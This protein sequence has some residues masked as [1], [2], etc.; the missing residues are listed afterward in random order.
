M[1]TLVPSKKYWGWELKENA[2]DL[3]PMSATEI[4]KQYRC[5]KSTFVVL[6]AG[7]RITL[8]L[9]PRKLMIGTILGFSSYPQKTRIALFE[10]ADGYGHMDLLCDGHQIIGATRKWQASAAGI[11]IRR[12]ANQERTEVNAAVCEE[13]AH[14]VHS[15]TQ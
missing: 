7:D 14:G 2:E 3:Q 10:F 8:K 11:Q 12:N 6:C 9:S 1:K 4:K 5:K 13:V 15:T